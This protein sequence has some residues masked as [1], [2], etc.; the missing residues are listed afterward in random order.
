MY[1][2]GTI[3]L[4]PFP[5]TDLAG[6]K[7]RP[8]VVLN[9]HKNSPDL[10]VSFVTSNPKHASPFCVKVKP[11]KKNGI[12]VPS[13]IICDKIATLDKKIIVGKIGECEVEI[14]LQINKVLTEVFSL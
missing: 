14:I 5:F 2:K 8:A 6:L 9:T 10:M 12:K 4:V 1:K 7:V 13:V 3:V 11:S